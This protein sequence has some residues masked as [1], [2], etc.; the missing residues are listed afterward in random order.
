[1]T[2]AKLFGSESLQRATSTGIQLLGGAGF[3]KKH[4]MQRHWR[5]A[6]AATVS[7]GTSQIQRRP[8][9]TD[10]CELMNSSGERVVP[11]GRGDS[12]A[13]SVVD[14]VA[15]VVFQCPDVSNALDLEMAEGLMRAI[16]A[17]ESDAVRSVVIV[18]EGP[19]FCADGDVSAFAGAA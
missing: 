3:M 4:D 7:A 14:G 13:Y 11:A 8:G 2:A 18:G 1:M 15:H 6:R 17:A 10:R 9:A 12:V 19:R 5:E 16:D